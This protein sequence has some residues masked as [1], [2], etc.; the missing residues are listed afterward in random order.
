MNLPYPVCQV[1]PILTAA[2]KTHLEE[3]E[4]LHQDKKIPLEKLM[5]LIERNIEIENWNG[6]KLREELLHAFPNN[7]LD[8]REQ[9]VQ[10]ELKISKNLRTSINTFEWREAVRAGMEILWKQKYIKKSYMEDSANKKE[11]DSLIF[12]LNEKTALFYTE[13]KEN[14]IKTGFSLVEV[15]HPLLIRGKKIKYFVCFAPKGD[16]EDQSLLFQLNDYFEEDGVE[17]KL[18]NQLK[19]A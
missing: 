10:E 14:V 15:E 2:D 18:K 7:I 5:G 4:L 3:F 8:E 16:S 6:N 11:E 9:E 12:F 1:N 19:N 13:P 17:Q